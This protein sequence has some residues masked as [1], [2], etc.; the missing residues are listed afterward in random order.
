MD[1]VQQSKSRDLWRVLYGLGI[2]HV[3][4]GVAK[5][6]GRCFAALEDVFACSVDQLTNCED[7]GE[8]IANSIVQWYGD[9]RN[10]KLVERLHKAGLNFKSELYIFFSLLME[11]PTAG[12]KECYSSEFQTDVNTSI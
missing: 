2:F 9:E 11:L 7:V 10:R 6:L 3:G 4:A 8:V 5:A 1:G 12:Y